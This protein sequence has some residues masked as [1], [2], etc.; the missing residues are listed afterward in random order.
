MSRAKA[1]AKAPIS[2]E[3]AQAAK[4]LPYFDP[5]VLDLTDS[6]ML[7]WVWNW[8]VGYQAVQKGIFYD[9]ITEAMAESVR[10]ATVGLDPDQIGVLW[11]SK[12]LKEIATGQTDRA[13]RTFRAGMAKGK[14][15]MAAYDEAKTQ[16]RRLSAAARRPRPTNFSALVAKIVE[17]NPAITVRGLLEELRRDASGIINHIDDDED[18]CIELLDH[19]G[20]TA[21]VMRID[22]LRGHLTR[23]KKK[24]RNESGL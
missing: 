5:R 1:G 23:A 12:A 24:L 7:L 18:G 3:S 13:A 6:E 11:L 19:P 21:K 10:V 2:A 9:D 17:G 16:R 20:K 22:A 4:P 15:D 14:M 8:W